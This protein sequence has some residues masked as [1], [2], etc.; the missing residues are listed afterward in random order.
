[1]IG[2]TVEKVIGNGSAAIVLLSKSE[3]KRAAVKVQKTSCLW[4]FHITKEVKRRLNPTISRSVVSPI[5]AVIFEDETM[6]LT[7]YCDQGSILD[8]VNVQIKQ[9]K[10]QEVLFSFFFSFFLSGKLQH[11]IVR[12]NISVY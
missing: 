10:I 7:E 4:E 1:M 3:T 5:S 8:L 11:D 12:F 2:Y 6:M 9:N